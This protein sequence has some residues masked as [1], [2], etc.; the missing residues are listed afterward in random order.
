MRKYKE[1][2]Q[3]NENTRKDAGNTS[4]KRRVTTLNHHPI[5]ANNHKTLKGT[6]LKHQEN[7]LAEAQ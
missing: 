6:T 3:T 2:H 4:A 5:E 7:H 1:I